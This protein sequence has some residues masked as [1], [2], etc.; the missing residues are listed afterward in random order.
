M[1]GER[2]IPTSAAP[3]VATFTVLSNGQEVPREHQVL[4]VVIDKSVN[5][6]PAA[7]LVIRD[8]EASSQTFPV[9]DTEFFT[10]GKEIEIKAGYRGT[11]D[12]V[13]KG[14]AVTH[15][16]KVREQ[17]TM[18]LVYCKDKAFSMT[19][20]PRNRYFRE[21][22]DSDVLEEVIGGAGLSADV[23]STSDQHGELVQYNCTDW[24]FILTRVD[25]IGKICLVEDG[26]IKI[27]APDLSQASALN[28]EYGANLLT[29]D[30]EIDARTQFK[31]V[32]SVAWGVGEQEVLESE[33]DAFQGPQAGNLSLNELVNVH[34]IES[35]RQQH[36]GNL[37]EV[38]LRS[39]SKARLLKSRL[40]KIRGRAKFQ[41]YASIA[42]G[43][44]VDIN[45]VGDRFNGSVFVSAI[46]HEIAGG[47]WV[48]ILE[49]GLDDRW[50]V[51]RFHVTQPLAGALI[52]PVGGLHIGTV[53]QLEDDPLGEKR[54]MVR[55]PMIDPEDD[56]TWARV[57][58]L[59]AGGER[60]SFFRPEVGDEVVVG[61][62]QDDPRHPV[63]LGTL[64]SSNKPA[65]IVATADNHEKG[66]VTRSGMKLM[67]D[68]DQKNVL[69]E[70]PDGNTV[71]LS[72]K[73]KAIT[74]EDQHGNK[75]LMNSEGITLESI[76]DITLKATGK[77]LGEGSDVTMKG[78]ATAEFSASGT[79]TIKG[80]VVQI[81]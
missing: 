54:L 16:L 67:F 7:T 10:P 5:R 74:L 77:L 61:F 35:L 30:A 9:S 58:T 60:G 65:P 44:L 29:F 11:E 4:S 52:P 45:G 72:G 26:E 48:T 78:Q 80:G 2:L 38:E 66:F 76:K 79:N 27:T 47:N 23:E 46:R 6:I 40:A 71:H 31:S 50:F 12:T 21:Q 34:G 15:S 55:L 73:E 42:P 51:E 17:R 81:N 13:F 14:V 70:T 41:G 33:E 32:K 69:I 59:D 25:A 56:G 53:T 36:S 8:G 22:T 1:A 39:W 43:Q 19:L 57:A 37:K 75:I 20:S 68:D 64:H 3:T 24:D 63:V 18:L 49:F 62:V 28:L